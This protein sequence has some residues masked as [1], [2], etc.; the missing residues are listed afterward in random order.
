MFQKLVL[1]CEKMGLKKAENQVKMLLGETILALCRNTLN[2]H[3]EICVEGLI[4]ITLDSEEIF[5]VNINQTIKNP[6]VT[7][8]RVKEE[9]HK[10]SHSQTVDNSDSS[11]SDSS[12][13]DSSD[14]HTSS[15][16]KRKKKRSRKKKQKEVPAAEEESHPY[17]SHNIQSDTSDRLDSGYQANNHGT[18]ND[19]EN[20]MCIKEEHTNSDN[21]DADDDDDLVFVKE[22]TGDIADTSHSEVMFPKLSHTFQHSDSLYYQDFQ[23]PMQQPAS[24]SSQHSPVSSSFLI[25]CPSQINLVLIKKI[26]S[27]LLQSQCSLQI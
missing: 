17:M 27:A 9:G 8:K 25:S 6:D 5:L 26:E 19:T 24:I 23:S 15:A 3:A 21:D 11:S 1:L 2:Y 12:S 10:R 18:E 20:G 4:G 13:E 22:E 14:N 16:S 7:G